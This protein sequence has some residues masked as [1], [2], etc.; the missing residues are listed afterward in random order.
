MDRLSSSDHPYL[1]VYLYLQTTDAL[2]ITKS[3]A[4]N[5]SSTL[6]E[7]QQ[8]QAVNISSSSQEVKEDL[9]ANISANRSDLT[10]DSKASVRGHSR[11]EV[12]EGGDLAFT[13]VL[14]AYP[15]IQ[16]HH[17]K[18]PSA[19]SNNGASEFGKSFSANGYK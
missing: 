12:Y 15:P 1:R 10:G 7:K 19:P 8:E 5:S 9:I 14:E 4:A 11:V 18:T 3:L 16:E 2:H 13:V 6:E 17:W